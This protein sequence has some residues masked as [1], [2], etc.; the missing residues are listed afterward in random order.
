M[1]T[2]VLHQF[3]SKFRSFIGSRSG[4]IS[5]IA[6]VSLMPIVAVGGSGLDYARMSS[7]RAA[8]QA[9]LDS[10][11]LAAGST[12]KINL[13][14]ASTVFSKNF[15]ISDVTVSNLAYTSSGETI[16]G[17]VDLSMPTTFL[18]ILSV[19]SLDFTVTTQAKVA[20]AKL[21]TATFKLVSAQGAFDKDIFI[22]TKN[23]AGTITS[24][25]TVLKYDYTYSKGV[26]TKNYT[27]AIGGSYTVTIQ[28]YETYGLGMIAYEDTTYTGKRTNPKY[29]YSDAIDASNFIKKT[30][31]CTASGGETSNWEDGGDS[32]FLDLVSNMTC[33]LST[34]TEALVR[35]SK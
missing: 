30:G 29:F 15:T 1:G 24:T 7:V 28:D 12:G 21:A 9:A 14:P 10:G 20:T 5:V 4:N 17:T 16:N 6:A 19:S 23:K 33:T 27:P 8:A 2:S 3:P 18:G 11:A 35:L 34:G 25:T 31:L 26:G 32:N 22:W 13:A